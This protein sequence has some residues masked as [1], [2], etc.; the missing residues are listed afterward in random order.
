[1]TTWDT[2]NV[3]SNGESERLIAKAMKQVCLILTFALEISKTF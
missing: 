2:A 1:V 3:Y